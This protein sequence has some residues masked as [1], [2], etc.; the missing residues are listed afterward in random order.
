MTVSI[1]NTRAQVGIDAPSVTVETHLSPGL[2]A[3]NI[4]GLPEAAVRESRDRVRSAIINAGFNFPQQRITVNLAP[5]DLPKHGGRFDAPIALGILLAAGHLGSVTVPEDLEFIGELTLSGQLLPVAGI[6]PAAVAAQRAGNRLILPPGNAEEAALAGGELRTAGQLLSLCQFLR[7]EDPL[8]EINPASPQATA[9]DTPCLSDVRGQQQ[10]RRALEIAAAG[11]HSMLLSGPPGSG[12][13]LLARRLPGL[14]P[15]LTSD[16]ALETAVIWSLT[17]PRSTAA[18]YQPPLR[19]PHHSASAVALVGGGSRPRPGEIS[20]AHHGVLFMDELPEF[21][22]RVLEV[23]REP[24]E[25]GEV[26]IARAATQTTFPARFQL[27]AAMN[28]CPCGYLGDPQR[29]CG[30]VCDRARRY[31]K[32]LSGPLLDRIDLHV[33]VQ[34]VEPGELIGPG[35]GESSATVRRRV[36]ASRQRQIQRQGKPNAALQG[37]ELEALITPHRDWLAPAMEKLGLSARSLHRSIRVARTLA[38]LEGSDTVRRQHISEA[39]GYRPAL[40]G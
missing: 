39:L 40:A 13:S 4:V 9:A 11:Q 31:Q 35:E 28:P 10:A 1:L 38:D 12:K 36:I 34:P 16:Q 23:L 25:T 21:D 15:A 22:R 24:L 5:A 32:K 37:R 2:P 8:S 3:F 17:R 29:G 20:L 30:Y 18:F 33:D 6:L 26:N 27:V 14:L 7:G 19:A